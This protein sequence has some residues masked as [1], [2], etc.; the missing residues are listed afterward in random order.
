MATL[1]DL[2]PTDEAIEAALRQEAV[3]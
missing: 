3:Q 1:L 2:V